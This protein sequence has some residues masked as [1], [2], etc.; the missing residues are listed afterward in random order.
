MSCRAGCYPTGSRKTLTRLCKGRRESALHFLSA[1]PYSS[2]KDGLKGERLESGRG[3]S[4][5]YRPW[6]METIKT[7]IV[8]RA[9]YVSGTV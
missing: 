9:H 1:H 2:V 6:R 5:R 3:L 4:P 7:S 8:L